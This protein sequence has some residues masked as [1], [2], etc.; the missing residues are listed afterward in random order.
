MLIGHGGYINSYELQNTR[1]PIF[2]PGNQRAVLHNALFNEDALSGIRLDHVAPVVPQHLHVLCHEGG[3]TLERQA[4]PLKDDLPLGWGQL[5]GGQL[6][7][8]V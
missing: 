7:W 5:E 8:S 3:L 4:V 1:T 6:E 2:I